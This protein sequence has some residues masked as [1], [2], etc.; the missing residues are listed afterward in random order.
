MARSWISCLRSWD[1]GKERQRPQHLRLQTNPSR[2][3][4]NF[5]EPMQRQIEMYL[6]S[7]ENSITFGRL[8]SPMV[9]FRTAIGSDSLRQWSEQRNHALSSSEKW[10][11]IGSQLAMA[12]TYVSWDRLLK[13]VSF[14]RW[15][16]S[17]DIHHHHHHPHRHPKDSRCY[18]RKKS[19]FF[20]I[21]VKRNGRRTT[22]M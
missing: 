10:I 11:S 13:Q 7:W 14:N 17:C 1:V 2:R 8:A 21:M 20:L 6:P 16:Y 18:K 19:S 15:P 3:R 9:S 12:A 5:S 4:S 22:M